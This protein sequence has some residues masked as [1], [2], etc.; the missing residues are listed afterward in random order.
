MYSSKGSS[1]DG[2]GTG[3]IGR[4]LGVILRFREP[5]LIAWTGGFSRPQMTRLYPVVREIID[6]HKIYDSRLHST[7][8]SEGSM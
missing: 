4:Y 6:Y 2:K 1:R 8:E 5:S 3:F 7:V